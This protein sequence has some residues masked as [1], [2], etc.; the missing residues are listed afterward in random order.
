MM[1]HNVLD[2]AL[3]LKY[4]EASPIHATV[5]KHYEAFESHKSFGINISGNPYPI[6]FRVKIFTDH[7]WS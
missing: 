7:F 6:S 4:F 5:L 2:N 1:L 3:V